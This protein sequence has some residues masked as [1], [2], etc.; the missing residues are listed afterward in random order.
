MRK[1]KWKKAVFYK[2]I[3]NKFIFC[4]KMAKIGI[5]GLTQNP[6]IREQN[7]QNIDFLFYLRQMR[8]FQV[9]RQDGRGR[10]EE[11]RSVRRLRP[12]RRPQVA[13]RSGEP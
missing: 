12:A 5:V 8:H 11:Q 7:S 9:H 2:I 10:L 3:N 13:Q 4:R 6:A 1:N